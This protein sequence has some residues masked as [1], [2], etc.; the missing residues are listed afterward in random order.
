VADL[1][2][3]AHTL[4]V[5]TQYYSQDGQLV[6]VDPGV[7]ADVVRS[8]GADP[9][10]AESIARSLE[11]HRL[12][13]WRRTLPPVFVTIAGEERR[14]WVHVP[15]GESVYVDVVLEDGSVRTLAQA[16]HLVAPREVDA[17]LIGEA[18][19]IVADDLPL[20]WHTVR[21]HL[22]DRI[23]QSPLVVTPARLDPEG[24]RG[25]ARMWGLMTQLY[26]LRSKRSWG[27][28]DLADLA[29][30]ATWSAHELGCDFVLVNPL[31]VAAPVEP[32]TPSP[33]L[34]SSR[35]FS[36]PLYLRIEE[37]P[38]FA[39]LAAAQR[40]EIRRLSRDVRRTRN[41]LLDRDATWAAK[42]D[43]LAIVRSVPLTP[44]RQA[45]FDAYVA[46]EGNGLVD[47]C[48][49]AAIAEDH[50][51]RWREWPAGL[52][53]PRSAEVA[54]WRAE[55]ADDVERHLW[56]QWLLDEQ[57]AESE[58]AAERVGMRIGIIHDLAVGAAFDGADAWRLQDVLAQGVSVG[59]PPDMYNQMG[60]NW[61]QPPWRP[62]ALAD[63]A[64]IPYRDMLR[65]I[66]RNAGGLRIDHILGLF[67]MWWV[68]EG[69]TAVEGTY[70]TFDHDALVGILALE[71]QRA[72]ALVIGEDLGTV[73][74][75]VAHALAERG[76]LGTS[77]LWFERD[78]AGQIRPPEHWRRDVLA[79]VTVHDLPPTA[80]YLDGEHVRLRADL[81]LLAHSEE[82]EAQA[83]STERAEWGQLLRERGLLATDSERAEA[84]A[85]ADWVIALHRLVAAS[86]ARLIGVAVPDLVGQ[87]QAQ[88]QP[89]TH[90]EY[91][92][93]RIPLADALGNPVTLEELGDAALTIALVEVMGSLTD[94][95]G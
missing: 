90:Q 17:L 38:E 94:R 71:A 95:L 59:A 40:K 47:A 19:F 24:L 84:L 92:N 12:R 56:M 66:L 9:T 5:A 46:G 88:N 10:D 89:G 22:A 57:L 65:T 72:G 48:T 29:D 6:H 68:P 67:R 37:I 41:G 79:S 4:G 70:V 25:D 75:W 28:G 43:A 30:L 74:P 45:A 50:G 13:D 20:G 18:S 62:D 77:I 35:R 63:A 34:P 44:G 58:S 27:I 76:I 23:E 36:N 14:I 49:W 91:P 82:I 93:W 32:M 54:H 3:L 61:A 64:F 52:T 53:H 16:E 81:G 11:E 42:R 85:I 8:L 51:D 60:Q 69:R 55:R 83:A 2:E 33:Y 80:G 39:Y 26:S 73:E 31:H 21:A 15:H 78:E 86:P 1:T 87:V 7:V